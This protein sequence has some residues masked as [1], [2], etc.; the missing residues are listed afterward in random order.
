MISLIIT[1]QCFSKTTTLVY[2]CA[3]VSFCFYCMRSIFTQKTGYLWAMKWLQ[4]H[5]HTYST[6]S[7]PEIGTSSRKPQCQ[8]ERSSVR[9]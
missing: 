4:F 1:S 3:V 5:F 6:C 8:A 7:P 2:I 9:C